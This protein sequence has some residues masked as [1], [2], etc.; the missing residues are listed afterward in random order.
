MLD[1]LR[2]QTSFTEEEA[3]PDPNA[4][5]PPKPRKPRRTLDQ[6][7]GMTAPQRFAL[8][9]MLFVIVCLMGVMFLLISGKVA[10]AFMF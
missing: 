2:D 8:A 7:T 1:N 3:P 5:K 6:M 9:V 10:P 4:P